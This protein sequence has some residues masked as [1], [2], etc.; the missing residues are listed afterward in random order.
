[1]SNLT[2]MEMA[3]LYSDSNTLVSFFKG[4]TLGKV[5]KEKSFNDIVYDV[6]E[7]EDDGTSFYSLVLDKE[8]IQNNMPDCIEIKSEEFILCY[9][10]DSSVENPI[11]LIVVF[12]IDDLSLEDID[13]L[14]NL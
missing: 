4:M 10:G 5:I 12:P 6:K 8:Y 2:P 11:P 13:R 3:D 7:N 14:T 9:K 1:M